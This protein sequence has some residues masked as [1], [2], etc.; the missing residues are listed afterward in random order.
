MVVLELVGIEK[1]FGAVGALR[2]AH[3]SAN[4][5]EIVGLCGEKGS[6][7]STL[8]KVLSGVHP[9]GSYGGRVNLGGRE[10]RLRSPNDMERAGIAVVHQRPN[11]VPQLSVAQNLLLGREPR[12]FGLVDEARLEA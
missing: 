10:L 8:V 1:S 7:K 3:F 2:G 9:Y 6:G 4:D 12:R 5:G 11:L